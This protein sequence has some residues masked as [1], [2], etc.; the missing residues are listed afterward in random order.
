MREASVLT[1]LNG[2]GFYFADPIP[3]KFY[4]Y[5]PYEAPV[6]AVGGGE[7]HSWGATRLVGERGLGWFR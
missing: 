2:P 3:G 5:L 6:L 7:R 4:D 1:I